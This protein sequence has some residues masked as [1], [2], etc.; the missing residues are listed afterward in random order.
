MTDITDD[1]YEILISDL[2]KSHKRELI[3]E[4]L[5]LILCVIA[6]ILAVGFIG[7]FI[8]MIIKFSKLS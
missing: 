7:G 4:K 1:N 2:Y 8:S 3:N 6:M 5:F